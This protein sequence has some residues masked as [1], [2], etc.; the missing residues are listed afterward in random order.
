MKILLIDQDAR[1]LDMLRSVLLRAKHQVFVAAD[2]NTGFR[3]ACDQKPDLIVLDIYLGNSDGPTLLQKLKKTPQTHRIPL[4][5][6]SL[7]A[8]PPSGQIWQPYPQAASQLLTYQAYLPKPINLNQFMR[9]VDALDNNTSTPPVGPSFI[10]VLSDDDLRHAL[11]EQLE[12]QNLPTE[13]YAHLAKPFHAMH[14]RSPIGLIIERHLIEDS[15][16]ADLHQLRQRLPDFGLIVL[17]TASDASPLAELAQADFVLGPPLHQWQILKA[18]QTLGQNKGL[19]KRLHHLSAELLALNSRLL[20]SQTAFQAQNEELNLVNRR[21]YEEQKTQDLLSSMIV[22]DL[23]APLSAL[24]ST[25]QFLE[26][27]PHSNLS[28]NS[29]NFI[30]RGSAAGQQMLRM[31]ESLLDERKLKNQNMMLNQEPVNLAEALDGILDMLLPLFQMYN[32]HPQIDLAPNLPHLFADPII[33][34]RVLENLL[35]NALKYTP[36][37]GKIFIVAK[38]VKAEFVQISIADQ[39]GG[40]PPQERERIFEPFAQLDNPLGEQTRRGVGLGLAFCKLAV[41][42][43]GGQIWVDPYRDI[44]AAFCFTVSIFE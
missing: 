20:E 16:W 2:A 28:Q 32:T 25:F 35:D 38:Q 34:Q 10:L 17:Q 33:L 11:S 13:A 15:L 24:I 1:T 36:T 43:M 18:V 39:G 22:H 29:R 3:L 26:I 27:D 5:I 44:G 37:E 7:L 6:I 23:K 12:A 40:I 41:E 42:A 19:N 4:I 14:L 21:L 8:V 30:K 31:V 9:Q